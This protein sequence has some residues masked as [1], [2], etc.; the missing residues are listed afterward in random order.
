MT[1]ERITTGSLIEHYNKG[2]I[3]EIDGKTIGKIDLPTPLLNPSMLKK[4]SEAI[5][6]GIKE[7][8]KDEQKQT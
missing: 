6:Q 7:Q 2:N 8:V 5:I 4:F 1:K 3:K